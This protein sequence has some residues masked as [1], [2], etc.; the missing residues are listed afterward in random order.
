MLVVAG[1]GD[2]IGSPG[3]PHILPVSRVCLRL[4]LGIRTSHPALIY[5]QD[6][7]DVRVDHQM[8]SNDS[9]FATFSYGNVDHT[10]PDPFP[11][12]AGGGSFSG[13]TSNFALAAGI[14]D[15]HTF[16]AN[17]I[18]EFKIGY[19][20]YVVAAI[21]FFARQNIDHPM[22]VNPLALP[23]HDAL[24]WP[25]LS[26]RGPLWDISIFGSADNSKR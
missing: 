17:K 10:R 1:E 20:R 8:T 9:V 23:L 14:S 19:M 24:L 11:G 6:S 5:N 2:C 15:V 13:N 18:N 16:S 21:P 12:L 4:C 26:Q 22:I 25:G 7:F 3:E